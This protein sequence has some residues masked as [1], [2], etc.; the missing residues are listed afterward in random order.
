MKLNLN[1]CE[2]S[3]ETLFVVTEF[4]NVIGM[5]L[6]DTKY[7]SKSEKL[8]VTNDGTAIYLYLNTFQFAYL[9]IKKNETI[10]FSG[11][12]GWIHF[13]KLMNSIYKIRRMVIGA[14]F[15]ILP[16]K[17]KVD[18]FKFLY[19]I[20]QNKFIW[21]DY[22]NHYHFDTVQTIHKF[23]KIDGKKHRLFL[24]LMI[25]QGSKQNN[26]KW[27]LVAH[28]ILDHGGSNVTLA[29]YLLENGYSLL[30]LDLPGNGISEGERWS[31]EDFSHYAI[32]I[33]D[34]VK[35]MNANLLGDF[36]FIGHSTGTVGVTDGL[37]NPHTSQRFIKL[38]HRFKAIVYIAPL[39]RSFAWEL[40]KFSMKNFSGLFKIIFD[41]KLPRLQDKATS[42]K[43]YNEKSANDLLSGKY[44]PLSWAKA[45]VLWNEKNVMYG[46]CNADITIFQGKLDEVVDFSYN[47]PYLQER[48]RNVSVTMIKGAKHSLQNEP[49]AAGN[50]FYMELTKYLEKLD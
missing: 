14:E 4:S 8:F 16:K 47:I 40:S 12:L 19:G 38:F 20:K 30:F 31:I 37:L 49:G 34:T 39:I 32:A 5:T 21:D 18:L 25:N 10:I 13:E 11:F 41:E 3:K 7:F 50:R 22:L 15:N 33:E 27:V 43:N 29:G 17:L 45:L 46:K 36:I 24:H 6:T 44:A 42:D 23:I 1:G 26:G 9:Y 48:F 28:G 2:I 35:W